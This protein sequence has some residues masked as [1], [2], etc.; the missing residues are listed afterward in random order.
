MVDIQK[1]VRYWRNGAEE[2][3]A[4]ALE[5][6]ERRK[7]RHALFI[8]HLAL[9]KTLKAHV[10][11]V[12]NDLAPRIHNLVKLSEIA[13]MKLSETDID[14]LAEVNEFNIEGRYPEMLLPSPTQDEA[15]EYLTRI[16]KV[17]EWLNNQF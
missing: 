16:G 13:H 10:C 8:A 12:T 3:W 14:L 9:E 7:I 4:V 11:R 2:D 17:L 6:I 1:Q 15:D 5:L